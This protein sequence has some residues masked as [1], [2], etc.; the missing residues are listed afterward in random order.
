M[1]RLPTSVVPFVTTTPLFLLPERSEGERVPGSL[2]KAVVPGQVESCLA[3]AQQHAKDPAGG[4]GS[5]I[6]EMAMNESL[7]PGGQI[8]GL[9]ETGLSARLKARAASTSLEVRTD[10]E[11]LAGR[12]SM[13]ASL[14]QITSRLLDQLATG[15]GSMSRSPAPAGHLQRD[16]RGNT[17][18]WD[19]SALVAWQRVVTVS[20]GGSLL[21]LVSLPPPA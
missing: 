3:A 12:S 11:I 7:G 18:P 17:V 4:S 20:A 19:G 13:G 9:S 21:A 15:E 16:S 14:A 1:T 8:A 5:V 6:R 2:D 10:S